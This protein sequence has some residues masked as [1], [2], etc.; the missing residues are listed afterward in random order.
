MGDVG[1]RSFKQ[2]KNQDHFGRKRR[3]CPNELLPK[4]RIVQPPRGREP[5]KAFEKT[6]RI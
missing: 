3:S 1:K 4:G 6:R 5:R 2:I